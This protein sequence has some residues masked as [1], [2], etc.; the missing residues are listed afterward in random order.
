MYHIKVSGFSLKNVINI[1]Y[2]KAK[3]LQCI[4]A[5]YGKPILEQNTCWFKFISKATDIYI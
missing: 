3:I 2:P 4:E 5:L 1:C